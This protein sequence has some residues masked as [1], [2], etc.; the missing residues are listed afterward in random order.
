M[1]GCVIADSLQQETGYRFYAY[2]SFAHARHL[3]HSCIEAADIE[4]DPGAN[5]PAVTGHRRV[6]TST[7]RA[8]IFRW[9][10]ASQRRD[11]GNPAPTVSRKCMRDTVMVRLSLAG[12]P[13]EIATYPA[14]TPSKGR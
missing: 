14:M 11:S 4:S 13:G 5:Q 8:D 3:V 7:R 2:L 1:T 9:L 6:H 10:H 12:M